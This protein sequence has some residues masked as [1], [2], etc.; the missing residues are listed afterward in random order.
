[1]PDGIY[2]NARTLGPAKL[3]KE[4]IDIIYNKTRYYDFFRWH[5]YY[6]FHHIIENQY[7]NEICG[8]CEM[9]NN[10]TVMEK[11]SVRHTNLWWN[12]WYNGPPAE[13]QSAMQL[14]LDEEKPKSAGVARFAADIYNYIFNS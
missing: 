4:M 8:L 9:L 7:Y 1:M 2:L 3:A 10:K 6:S 5:E 11:Q 14:L 12:E 13:A